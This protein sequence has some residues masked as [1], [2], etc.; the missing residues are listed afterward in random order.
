M[1]SKSIILAVFLS[2]FVFSFFNIA[3]ADSHLHKISGKVTGCS[4]KHAVHVLIYEEAGFK[5]MNH[6]QENIYSPTKGSDCSVDFSMEVPAG[7]Y[8]L[9]SFEDKNGNGELDFFF[10][11]PK[12]PAGFYKFSGM[13]APKFEKMKIDVNGDIDSIEIVLP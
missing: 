11:I 4:S 1:K 9:A 13:G 5:G 8:A 12:E 6:S 2:V 10:F 7:P 3:N